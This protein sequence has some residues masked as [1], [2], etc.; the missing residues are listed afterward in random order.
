[1][2][3]PISSRSLE[4]SDDGAPLG[5]DLNNGLEA[6]GCFDA[7]ASDDGFVTTCLEKAKP[8]FSFAVVSF[9]LLEIPAIETPSNARGFGDLL[10]SDVCCLGVL[11]TTCLNCAGTLW[12]AIQ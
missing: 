9:L 2:R 6:V 5:D 1:M 12:I 4:T 7:S 8:C 3:F 10:G 11:V